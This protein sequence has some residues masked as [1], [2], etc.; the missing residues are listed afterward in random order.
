MCAKLPVPPEMEVHPV[1]ADGVAGLR[2]SVPVADGATILYAHGGGMALG[3][4]YGHRAIAAALAVASGTATVVPEYRL[5][6]EH[7]YPAAVDDIERTF[8]WLMRHGLLPPQ[9][10]MAGDPPCRELPRCA[11]PPVPAHGVTPTP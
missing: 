9:T 3:S 2:L 10:L 4:A 6:P 1:N 5:A 11:R 7:P 8:R